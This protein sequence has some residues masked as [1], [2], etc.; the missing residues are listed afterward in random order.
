M[1]LRLLCFASHSGHCPVVTKVDNEGVAHDVVSDPELR[2]R[3]R[4]V[5]LIV[6]PQ[7]KNCIYATCQDH[8][9]HAQLL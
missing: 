2:Y 8:Q 7:V 6:N 4:Y 5:D 1:L 9:L 3:Q